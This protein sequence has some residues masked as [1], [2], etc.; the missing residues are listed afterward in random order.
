MITYATMTSSWSIFQRNDHRLIHFICLLTLLMGISCSGSEN[1]Q[2]DDDGLIDST[3]VEP[4]D[5][6]I[7]VCSV[8]SGKEYP[9]FYINDST[10]HVSVDSGEKLSEI[11]LKFPKNV[12]C[13]KDSKEVISNQTVFD[14]SDFCNP[15]TFTISN[16]TGAY[17]KKRLIIYD[18]PVLIIDTPDGSP[19]I[20]REE[21]TDDCKV[22]IVDGGVLNDLGLADIKSRGGSTWYQE[23]KPYNLKFKKQV[24]LLGMSKSKHW[25]LLANAFYDRTQLHNDVAFEL[26]RMTDF[27]WVQKGHFVELILN[28]DHRGLYYL[29]EKI[30]VEDNKINI[31]KIRS[32]DLEGEALTGG[33]LIEMY[34]APG[35]HPYS[36]ST[37]Y[38]N[39]T[40]ASLS[41]DLGWIMKEPEED[42]PSEQYDYVKKALNYME[43]LIW[44]DDSLKTGKYRDFFDI[45]TAI[46]WWLVEE[47]ALNEEASRTK[48]LYLYKERGDSRFYLGPPWDFDAWA[49]GMHYNG[50][51]RFYCTETTL[52]FRQLF[53]DAFFINRLKEKWS[54]LYPKWKSAI[55]DYID[56]QYKLIYNS[57]LRNETLLWTSWHELYNYPNKSYYECVEDMKHN[58]IV[59]LDWMDNQ[60]NNLK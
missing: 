60:I 31:S 17:N 24:G 47:V 8:A 15:A 16:S 19:I 20:S 53:K 55:P 23:K 2:T 26:A 18:L 10:I 7:Y 51:C 21:R 34:E 13:Y 50:V 37:D 22:R 48:N 5:T 41:L 33:Y 40:G 14:V 12:K 1:H 27:P 52:Y 25:I 4:S 39:K 56:S 9:T 6:S 35:Q 29:V 59:Q 28:G 46:N 43:S 11:V 57:A 38:F 54:I 44:S 3:Y 49:F 45:E 36:F 42:I 30:G 58:F 32:T